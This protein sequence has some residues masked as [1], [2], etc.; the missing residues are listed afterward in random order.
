MQAVYQAEIAN[1]DIKVA[2]ANLL[3]AEKFIPETKEFAAELA[4]AVWAHRAEADK[5]IAKL[6]KD[7]PIDRISKVDHSILRVALFELSSGETPSSVVIN[8]AVEM[9]KRY[10]GDESSKFI[11]GILGA[12]VRSS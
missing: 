4:K 9:A 12:Q 6:S 1:S 10:S 2:I 8:E 11:N 3:E 5:V 7:W